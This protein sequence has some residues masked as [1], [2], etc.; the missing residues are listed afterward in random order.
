MEFTGRITTDARTS[1]VKGGKEV[2]NFS[3]ALNE[4]YKP[5]GST[6]SKEF[7]TYIDV[8]WWMNTE[9]SKM[10]RKGAIVTI[11]GRIYPRAYSDMEGN[12]KASI[13]CHANKIQIIQFAKTTAKESTPESVDITDQIGRAHV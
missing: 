12:P 11:S 9:I 6:E 7:T 3:M 13:N 8:A 5:K 1:V 10:L 4:R 2:V